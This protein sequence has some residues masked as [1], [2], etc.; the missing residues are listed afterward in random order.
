VFYEEMNRAQRV[1]RKMMSSPS[2]YFFATQCVFSVSD[3]LGTVP[4]KG[5]MAAGAPGL[6]PLFRAA[7][8]PYRRSD[9]KSLLRA[10]GLNSRQVA[11]PLNP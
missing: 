11:P 4:S 10:K 2:A 7:V 8:S 5:Q 3:H 1:A 6:A 9:A